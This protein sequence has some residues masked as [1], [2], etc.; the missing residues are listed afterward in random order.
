MAVNHPFVLK[1][2]LLFVKSMY[3]EELTH[4]FIPPA[5][6]LSNPIYTPAADGTVGFVDN[7]AHEMAPHVLALGVRVELFDGREAEAFQLT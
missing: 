3:A 4:M 5:A 2:L 7:T 1:S 6:A